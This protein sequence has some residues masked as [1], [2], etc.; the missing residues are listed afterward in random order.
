M[1]HKIVYV[2]I[3]GTVCTFE[4]NSNI[5][6]KSETYRTHKKKKDVNTSGV[7]APL[8][9]LRDI[10]NILLPKHAHIRSILI[11]LPI[12]PRTKTHPALTNLNETDNACVREC[13]CSCLVSSVI[14]TMNVSRQR[15]D[16]SNVRTH[17]S[18]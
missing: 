8:R 7:L 4:S 11:F 1:I 5:E 10:H 18:L 16:N 9:R 17:L 15:M 13:V 6:S 2:A 3:Q 12:Y 14:P